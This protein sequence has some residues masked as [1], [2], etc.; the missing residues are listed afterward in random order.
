MSRNR[1]NTLLEEEEV[2]LPI[3]EPEEAEDDELDAG[4]FRKNTKRA[5]RPKKN[6][7]P[8]IR[9]FRARRKEKYINEKKRYSA[10]AADEPAQ[11]VYSSSEKDLFGEEEPEEVEEIVI[12]KPKKRIRRPEPA[13]S[14]DESAREENAGKCAKFI[15]L[16]TQILVAIACGYFIFLTY[17]VIMTNYSYNAA[18]TIEPAVMNVGDIRSKREFDVVVGQ[19]ENCRKLYEKILILDYRV[20]QGIEDPMTLAPE[21]NAL[22]DDKR[23]V[24]DVSDLTGKIKG[25]DIPAKYSSIQGMM[26]AW[27]STDV[28]EYLQ[29]INDGLVMSDQGILSEALNRRTVIYDD[30]SII[31]QNLVAIGEPMNGVDLTDMKKWSPESYVDT[32]VNG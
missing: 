28:A 30:F 22:L 1:L 15:E 10:Q 12:E 19:Y 20:S 7:L 2:D 16:T 14:L 25:M 27:V 26:L 17:G 29:F 8:D 21:Y 32:Y 18:G 4:Y 23:N 13:P 24:N 11:T 6:S 5:T 3:V 9:N 31:T